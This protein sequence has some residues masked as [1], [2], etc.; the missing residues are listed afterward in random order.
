MYR[1][2]FEEDVKYMLAFFALNNKDASI[3][4]Q[5]FSGNKLDTFGSNINSFRMQICH[6]QHRIRNVSQWFERGG[7]TAYKM[8]KSA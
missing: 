4:V 7:G 8:S 1:T 5:I 2:V 3:I 6:V